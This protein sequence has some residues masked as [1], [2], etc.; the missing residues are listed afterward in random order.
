M[1]MI[2]LTSAQ[3]AKFGSLDVLKLMD[4]SFAPV[5]NYRA[6]ATMKIDMPQMHI[7]DSSATIYFKRPNRVK[8]VAREGF[9]MIPNDAIPGDPAAWI[10]ENFDAAYEGTGT[11]FGQ[12]VYVLKLVGKTPTVPSNVRMWVDKSRG[13]ILGT[14]S[15]GDGMTMKSRWGYTKVDGKYWLP[16]DITIEMTGLVAGAVYDPHKAKY[17]KPTTGGGAAIVKITKYTVNKGVSD[18]VF[19]NANK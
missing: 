16:A 9:T 2:A 1:S 8:V 6:E 4:K 7:K 14:E 17:S 12:S 13:V 15:S 10:R 19:K 11:K 3:A 18:S 5:K